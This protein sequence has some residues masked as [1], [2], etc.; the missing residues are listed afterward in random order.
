DFF[1]DTLESIRSFDAES[2]RSTG[3]LRSID[4]VPLSEV[5][6]TTESISR[7]RTAYVT[8]FGVPG[9]EDALYEAISTG[10]RYP[11]LE[12]WLP[13]FH[14][15]LDTV[16]DY[17]GDAAVVIDHLAGEAADERSAQI[18]DYQR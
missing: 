1:G 12:H 13:L 3:Q 8:R 5:R 2:Q 14:E 6:L 9:P 17:A 4:L 15:R 16:F 7:F 18:V 10:R 11:G